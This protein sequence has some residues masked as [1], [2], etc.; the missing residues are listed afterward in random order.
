MTTELDLGW[1]EPSL[2]GLQRREASGLSTG[3]TRA[4]AERLGVDAVIVRVVFIVLAFCAGLGIALYAWGTGLTRGPRGTRPIDQVLPGFRSWSPR[5][6]KAALV[7]STIIFVAIFT[8]VFP[9][10]WGAGV[11]VLLALLIWRRRA[12][13]AGSFSPTYGA[14]VASAGGM[15]TVDGLGDDALVEHWRHSISQAAGTPHNAIAVPGLLPEVDLYNPDDAPQARPASPPLRSNWWAGASILAAMAL[16]SSLSHWWL[17]LAGTETLAFTTAAGGALMV[18]WALLLRRRRVPRT[19]L[20]AV[21]GAVVLSGWLAVQTNALPTT[22]APETY[23]VRVVADD[24]VVDLTNM[25][26]SGYSA[27]RVE[28]LLA[29]VE[30]ILPTAP[31]SLSVDSFAAEVTDLGRTSTTAAEDGAEDMA[32]L[33]DLQVH[34]QLSNVT[35]EEHS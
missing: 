23:T 9:L 14:P 27:V 1:L 22:T 12:G 28:A 33:V 25:D 3:L 18:L 13:R 6:Q 29:N 30:I 20:A 21:A 2:G 35:I 24:A 10:Q 11:L 8:P 31:K 16:V 7:V 19:A 5:A 17:G 32:L 4:I 15:H 26:L 34:A